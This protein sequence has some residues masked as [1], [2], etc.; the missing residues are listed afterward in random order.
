MYLLTSTTIYPTE[1]SFPLAVS[2]ALSGKW[3][4]APMTTSPFTSRFDLLHIADPSSLPLIFT[5][6]DIE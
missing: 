3:K 4:P 5:E 1:L 2:C 6:E